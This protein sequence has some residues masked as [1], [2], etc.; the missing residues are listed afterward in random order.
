[1]MILMLISLKP[2]NL[3]MLGLLIPVVLALPFIEVWVLIELAGRIG[4]LETL[5]L[6][7]TTG[8]V[9]LMIIRNEGLYVLRKARSSVT[10]AEMTRNLADSLLLV[11][12]AIFL[13][14]P[15]IITDVIGFVTVFRPVRERLAVKVSRKMEAG[16]GVYRFSI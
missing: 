2:E 6:V 11:L 13:L 9:G 14:T 10:G 12:S 3:G 16:S 4:F 8:I 15:G 7:L 1:M 5:G